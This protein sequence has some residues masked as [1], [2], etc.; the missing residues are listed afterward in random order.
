[1]SSTAPARTPSEAV[2]A[3]ELFATTLPRVAGFRVAELGRG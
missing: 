2:V 1:M 3:I